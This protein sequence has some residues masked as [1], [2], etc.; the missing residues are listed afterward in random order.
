MDFDE[1]NSKRD[2]V[3]QDQNHK[4]NMESEKNQSVQQMSPEIRNPCVYPSPQ[5]ICHII[6]MNGEQ[7]VIR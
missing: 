7:S 4:T 2:I 5:I 3:W 1:K 6:Q